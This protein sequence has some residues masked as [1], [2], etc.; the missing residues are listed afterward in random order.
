MGLTCAA[1]ARH[2]DIM[3]IDFIYDFG[4][5]NAYFAYKIL[6]EIAARTGAHIKYSPILLGGV[7]KLTN[8]KPP[9]MAFGGVKNKL[10]YQMLEIRRFIRDHKL[11]AFQMNP[12]FPVNTLML[13]RGAVLAGMDGR[14]QDYVDLGF[15]AMW[16]DGLKMDDPHIFAATLSEGGFGDYPARISSPEVKAGLMEATQ[17]AVDKGVFGAPSFFVGDEMFFGKDRLSAVEA[18]VKRQLS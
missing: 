6:P 13:M 15:K 12:N 4:S 16:E 14:A 11:S 3:N 2:G 10:D 7:F 18:E 17:S 9:M 5:P 1:F 8:N